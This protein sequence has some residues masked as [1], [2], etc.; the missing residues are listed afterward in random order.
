MTDKAHIMTD[1][2]IE[3]MERHLS[4]IYR[5]AEKAISAEMAAYV[6]TI[7][8]KADKLLKAYN[9]A[10]TEADKKAAKMAYIRFY[11]LDVKREARF[12]KLQQDA[13]ETLYSA[14]KEAAR[15][16]NSKTANIYAINYNQEG[17][18]IENDT[19][20]EYK[21]KPVTVEEAEEYGQITMQTVDKKKD[22]KWN[23]DNIVKAVVAGAVLMEA[24]DK[25]FGGASKRTTQKN[26]DSAY[27]QASDTATDAESKGRLD[28]MYRASDEGFHVQKI[29]IATLDNRTRDTHIDYDG[30]PPLELDDEYNTG[31]KKPRDRH[32]PIMAEVCNCRCR[33]QHT[34]GKAQG[35]VRAAREGDV[36]GSYKKAASY[37]GTKTIKVPDMSYE[38]WMKWRSQS[39]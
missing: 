36:K 34:M 6:K 15:Y 17:H 18:G 31:L 3:R 19:G 38:E 2:E 16:I 23:A 32:C 1:K 33:I 11:T 4:V 12:K 25:V 5:R 21:F 13:A 20:K 26:R 10:E 27:R 37:K 28:S 8:G 14:N 30:M 29:W 22:T 35:G 9:E 24:A 39:N 7:K